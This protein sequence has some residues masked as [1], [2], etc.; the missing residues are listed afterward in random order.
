MVA[1]PAEVIIL[2]PDAAFTPTAEERTAAQ[3]IVA[4]SAA[5]PY[6]DTVGRKAT[7]PAPPHLA[8]A[9]ALRAAARG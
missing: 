7:M 4:L 6:A 8:Q 9:P 5:S 3:G 2:D 1:S